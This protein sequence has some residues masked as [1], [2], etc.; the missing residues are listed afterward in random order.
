MPSHARS[1]VVLDGPDDQRDALALA[2]RDQGCDVHATDDPATAALL[3]RRSPNDLLIVDLGMGAFEPVP[4]WARRR[5]DPADAMAPD[6]TRGYAVL[7]ALDRLPRGTHFPVVSLR[8]TDDLP[9]GAP[10]MAVVDCIPKPVD[11]A[12][13]VERLAKALDEPR[14]GPGEE[15]GQ[16]LPETDP[17]TIADVPVFASLHKALRTALLADGDPRFR[18]WFKNVMA[19]HDFTTHEA[20]TLDEAEQLALSKRPWLVVSDTALDGA[21]GFELCRR[22]RAKSL[23]CHTPFVFCSASDDYTQ[24][25]LGLS[26]GA[27]EF[28]SKR[29]S[30]REFLI[31]V[32]V[33]LK[34]YLDLRTRRGFTAGLEGRLDLIGPTG[35]LQ[36]C[37]GGRF[38]GK[39]S[40]QDEDRKAE[41][42]FREG[43]ITAARLGEEAGVEAVYAFLAWEHGRF[44]FVPGAMPASAALVGHF[45]A[46]LIEGCRLLDESRRERGP[47]LPPPLPPRSGSAED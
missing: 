23:T 1:I 11:S 21:D 27:D 20:A 16:A 7:R 30:G 2:L 28:L 47:E 38:S 13:V 44:E 12:T 29:T 45:D 15:P 46:L 17:V 25:Y 41:F 40:V 37:H 32:Q 9:R 19:L 24:R 10:R 5:D 18:R 33:V 42:L 31:R 34:R 39:L 8:N 43:E 6:V 22:L 36:M 14:Q 26:V 3:T 35:V 4:R